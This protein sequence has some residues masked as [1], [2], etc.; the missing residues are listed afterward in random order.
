M[1]AGLRNDSAMGCGDDMAT[2]AYIVAT[3]IL[4]ANHSIVNN[5]RQPCP[6][7]EAMPRFQGELFPLFLQPALE[8]E[9]SAGPEALKSTDPALVDLP[10]WDGIEGVYAAAAVFACVE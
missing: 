6:W 2:M 9:E 8:I 3:R 10:Y 4:S 7:T 5:Y 1:D